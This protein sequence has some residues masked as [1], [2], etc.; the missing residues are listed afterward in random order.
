MDEIDHFK[1]FFVLYSGDV[2]ADMDHLYA[3]RIQLV[4]FSYIL[5]QDTT[6]DNALSHH[7]Y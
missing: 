2:T 4:N 7:Q 5:I 1:V 3:K 6:Q